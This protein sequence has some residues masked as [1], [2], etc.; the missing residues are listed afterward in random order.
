M[1]YVGIEVAKDKHECMII[2]EENKIVTPCFSF[3]NTK[4]GF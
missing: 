2:I 1:I 3:P 4:E